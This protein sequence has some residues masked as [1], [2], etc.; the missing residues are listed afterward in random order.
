MT[1]TTPADA[2]PPLPEPISGVDGPDGQWPL[3]T[4][5][6]MQAYAR[7]A[8]QQANEAESDENMELRAIL[9]KVTSALG[10]GAFCSAACSLEFLRM[11]PAEVEKTVAR[12][13][14]SQPAQDMTAD[15]ATE[16]AAIVILTHVLGGDI[17]DEF[18]AWY[19][20]EQWLGIHRAVAAFLITKSQPAQEPVIR[21]TDE[22]FVSD[23][24]GEYAAPPADDE[25]VR[26]LQWARASANTSKELR[27]AIDAYLAKAKR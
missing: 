12:L 18:W 7:A 15:E 14:A 8:S 21:R 19:K 11:I 25:A 27:A 9:A 4:T 17:L 5:D 16:N 6:Q 26:L 20:P 22:R 24:N 1:D 13:K 23:F 3:F 10:T 2:L